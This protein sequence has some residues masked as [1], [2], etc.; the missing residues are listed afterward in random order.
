V[1]LGKLNFAGLLAYHQ[2]IAMVLAKYGY[3]L[4]GR[5][6]DFNENLLKQ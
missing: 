6:T 2:K 5:Q 3:S 4:C 1:V